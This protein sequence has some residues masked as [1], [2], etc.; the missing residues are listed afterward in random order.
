MVQ[1][2]VHVG[3]SC[4]VLHKQ[5]LFQGC[6]SLAH[7]VHFSAHNHNV[8]QSSLPVSATA[9]CAHLVGCCLTC[10]LHHATQQNV[11]L[12]ALTLRSEVELPSRWW[13]PPVK[14]VYCFESS[15]RELRQGQRPRG[16]PK[17][18]FKDCIKNNLKHSGTPS[19]EL[20][21]LAQDR[22]AWRSLT[23]QAQEILRLTTMITLP[24]PE[25]GVRPPRPPC[26]P[27]LHSSTLL[28]TS[29]HFQNRALQPHPRRW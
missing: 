20:E 13:F 2:T 14:Q 22:S 25:K 1:C 7:L 8:F 11:N 5:S 28:P 4:G 6:Q 3:A 27:L 26:P 9:A 19:T 17:K 12:F 15:M 24:V 10:W 16:R 18:R 21:N 29:V 23:R